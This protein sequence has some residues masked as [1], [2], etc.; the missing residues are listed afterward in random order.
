MKETENLKP[1]VAEVVETQ[2]RCPMHKVSLPL[3]I[4]IL[5]LSP[6]LAK[7][8]QYGL[9][10]LFPELSP[11]P[12]ALAK[13]IMTLY[14]VAVYAVVLTRCEIR[15]PLSTGALVL[16]LLGALFLIAG[17][18]VPAFAP[19]DPNDFSVTDTFMAEKHGL[20]QGMATAGYGLY[21][22]A[23]LWMAVLTR[24]G[25]RLPLL[26]GVLA[27]G[28]A[29]YD[30]MQKINLDPLAVLNDATLL[31]L[32]QISIL[33]MVTKTLFL[34]SLFSYAIY[35]G[36]GLQKGKSSLV[37]SRLT[38]ETPVRFVAWTALVVVVAFVVNLF[39][40]KDTNSISASEY[41]YNKLIPLALLFL[42]NWLTQLL[43]N[44]KVERFSLR[45][46]GY[47]V[48][49]VP[50]VLLAAAAIFVPD[51]L[52]GSEAGLA[53]FIAVI[54]LA[55]SLFQGFYFW[56]L[57]R[58]TPN[59]ERSFYTTGA[60]AG[61]LP[62]FLLMTRI[63]VDDN[64]VEL[65]LHMDAVLLPALMLMLGAYFIFFL[66]LALPALFRK[67]VIVSL[68]AVIAVSTLIDLKLTRNVMTEEEI[69]QE[70][71]G[72]QP[73][74]DEEMLSDDEYE[75]DEAFSDGDAEYSDG[76]AEYSDGDAE[77]TDGDAESVE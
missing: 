39:Y 50:I 40:L 18:I 69:L 17:Q 28:V 56:R 5:A 68:G 25:F 58:T 49:A 10:C 36:E 45:I 75:G 23:F 9:S 37:M 21:L 52:T 16:L 57:R 2:S 41:P 63:A 20:M 1:Q 27:A 47:F 32:N 53:E 19:F 15:K 35:A 24:R 30:A 29:L 6:L 77:Y 14:T 70:A 13:V 51:Y 42:C 66:R 61:L 22:V 62:L 43:V 76:D 73:L 7:V 8:I 34:L 54:I 65:R 3:L 67:W 44:M 12:D 74:E 55:M 11:V 71:M 4:L 64:I 59:A 31:S 72:E 60:V 38:H 26:L 46:Y 33:L 48:W